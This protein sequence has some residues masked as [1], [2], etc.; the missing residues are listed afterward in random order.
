MIIILGSKSMLYLRE[1]KR[2]LEG[3]GPEHSSARLERFLQM[4]DDDPYVIPEGMQDPDVELF[5][6]GK[7]TIAQ[8]QHHNW[9]LWL[10]GMRARH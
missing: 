6:R 5:F 1:E 8:H 9:T 10:V 4:C 7:H 3:M 2:H